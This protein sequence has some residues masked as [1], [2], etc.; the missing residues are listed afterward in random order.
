MEF[1]DRIEKVINEAL[2]GEWWIEGPQSTF[3]D[4][5]ISD[6]NHAVLALEA[7]LGVSLEDPDAPEIMPFEPFTDEQIQ[8]L[9]E[10]DA[11]RDA[12]E[13]LKDGTDPR[14]YAVE[15][16]GYI[17]VQGDNF[18]MWEFNQEA[19][20][21]I[22]NFLGEF[23]EEEIDI[24]DYAY[25]E[26]NKDHKTWTIQYKKL[27]NPRATPEALKRLAQMDKIYVQKIL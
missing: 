15:H 18:Q 2:R 16:L 10:Q 11:D 8:W 20:N 26:Q 23:E 9:I 22:Q 12:I 6:Y 21:D 14:D 27:M 7:A 5:D 3:A 13:A 1:I 19:L 4:V 17:R 24:D 25:I